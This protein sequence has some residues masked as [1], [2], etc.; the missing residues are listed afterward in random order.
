RGIA[1]FLISR[2]ARQRSGDRGRDAEVHVRDPRRQH[3]GWKLVPLISAP[4]PQPGDVEVGCF[5]RCHASSLHC[6]TYPRGGAA[7]GSYSPPATRTRIPTAAPSTVFPPCTVL[8]SISIIASS[9]PYP[10]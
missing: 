5:G 7:P 1:V 8:R 6:R 4:R 10:A 9:V 2:Q 3:V